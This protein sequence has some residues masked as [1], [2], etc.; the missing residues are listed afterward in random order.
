M[1]T[2]HGLHSLSPSLPLPLCASENKMC[3]IA[4]LYT[5]CVTVFFFV[6]CLVVGGVLGMGSTA[7]VKTLLRTISVKGLA[8]EKNK[9]K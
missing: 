2:A 5:L 6:C 4:I 3:I 1:T 8:P 7:P 9:I